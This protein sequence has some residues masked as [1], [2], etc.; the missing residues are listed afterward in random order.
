MVQDPKDR[1][2]Q[3]RIAAG[4]G[5]AAEAARRFNWPYSSYAA[6]EN[7]QNAI[8]L[9]N[10]KVYSRAFKV[11]A[12]WILTGDGGP[13]KVTV[14][15]EG[16]VGAGFVIEPLGE[17]QE[18]ERIDVPAGMGHGLRA[19][20]VRGNSMQPAYYD[21]DVIF[22]A[23]ETDVRPPKELLGRECVIR[24]R[25][26]HMYVKRLQKGTREGRFLLVSYNSDPIVDERID[27]ACPVKYIQRS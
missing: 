20:R 27:W 3:A 11:A 18:I 15:V 10:A 4:F 21:G 6:H 9:E 13:S 5:S 24:T 17:N 22:Y 23:P 16:Y 26:G 19:L 25:D 7:G 14:P 12:A 8:R 2:R 1:L